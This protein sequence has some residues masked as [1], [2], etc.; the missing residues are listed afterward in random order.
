MTAW[1]MRP[2]NKAAV[3]VLA[4]FRISTIFSVKCLAAL[5]ALPIFLAAAGVANARRFNAALIFAMN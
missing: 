4:G 3:A 1:A 2:F 5:V